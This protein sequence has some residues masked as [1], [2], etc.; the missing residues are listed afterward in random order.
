MM[1]GATAVH[2]SHSTYI[3]AQ[4]IKT[5]TLGMMGAM[6]ELMQ[7]NEFNMRAMATVPALA[8][9]YGAVACVRSVARLLTGRKSRADVRRHCRTLLLDA[10][11]LL[12][13]CLPSGGSGGGGGGGGGGGSGGDVGGFDGGTELGATEQVPTLRLGRAFCSM[14]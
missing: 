10:E 14:R 2:T 11:R 13:I 12:T 8:T 3:Q 9:A 7:Q 6:E 4:S 1:H 5:E